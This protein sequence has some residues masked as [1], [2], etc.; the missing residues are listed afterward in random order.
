ML[1]G[2][3]DYANMELFLFV[4]V[5]VSYNFKMI[6]WVIFVDVNVYFGII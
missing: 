2:E 4:D 5:N 1:D 3:F 6:S